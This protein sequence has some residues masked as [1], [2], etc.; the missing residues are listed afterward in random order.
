MRPIQREFV[1]YGCWVCP[2]PTGWSLARMPGWMCLKHSQLIQRHSREHDGTFE[3]LLQVVTRPWG[4]EVGLLKLCFRYLPQGLRRPG[5]FTL[6]EEGALHCPHPPGPG[7]CGVELGATRLRRPKSLILTNSAHPA[8]AAPRVRCTRPAPR[9]RC[10]SLHGAFLLLTCGGCVCP[11][12]CVGGG[13][14]AVSCGPWL[15]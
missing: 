12:C 10:V 7:S 2:R 11:A 9:V 8:C 5:A 13:G 6:G 15:A 14:R 4:R 3:L 1:R